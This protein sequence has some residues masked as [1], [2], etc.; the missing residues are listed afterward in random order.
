[1]QNINWP[2]LRGTSAIRRTTPI[3][4][5]AEGLYLHTTDGRKLLD[6]AG[7]AIV[8]NI[9]WGRRRVADRVAEITRECAY[10]VP[11][12]ITPSR[13]DLVEAL[14]LNWLP[15][16][17]RRIH[18]TSGGSDAIESAMKLAIQYHA[19]RGEPGRRQIISRNVSYHGT[20]LATTAVSGHEG[21]KLGLAHILNVHPT[22]ATP[23]PLRCPL[24]RYHP[25]AGRF[26]LDNLRATIEAE[27]PETIA[28][29]LAE[30]VTGSSGGAI[31]PP[32]EYWPGAKQICDEY[33]ILMIFD[34][35]MTG[36]GRTGKPFAF[37]HWNVEPDILVGGKGLAGGY[38]PIGGVFA[39]DE[40]GEAIESAGWN[41]MFHTLG[42]HPAA[43]GAAAE[44][45]NIMT[46]EKLIA[47]AASQ[48]ERLKSRLEEVF[49]GHPFV[50]EV[51]N[52]GLLAAVEILKDCETI[53][54]FPEEAAV[55]NRIIANAL[56]HDVFFYPGG[57]GE[58]RDI[59][60]IG[61]AFTIED[62]QIEQIADVLRAAVDEVT[63]EACRSS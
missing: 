22:A 51:R 3:I 21:R 47:R 35:V 6:A 12:W 4:E 1:M 42:A 29:L 50:A 7:G 30:P 23:Y 56:N 40:I 5:R 11:P 9:G 18:I 17:L 24:G 46:E 14:E 36:F 37:Q 34:E 60:C 2:F 10:V 25:D 57:T 58:V 19:A 20:T 48:G 53:E 27:G 61:P 39:T 55:T 62:A 38:A 16:R 15:P 33:G 49:A 26:Y 63:E 54:P 41:V 13:I 44:V 43:C 31:V 59:V 8:A 45:L 28:A 52:C 32:D